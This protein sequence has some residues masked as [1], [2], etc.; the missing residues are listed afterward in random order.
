M[1]FRSPNDV[2]ASRN[3]MT[4]DLIILF[5]TIRIMLQLPTLHNYWLQLNFNWFR[6]RWLT[7]QWKKRLTGLHAQTWL[8]IH[9]QAMMHFTADSNVHVIKRIDGG[10]D[11]FAAEKST[12]DQRQL[13]SITESIF[14]NQSL[15]HSLLFVRNTFATNFPQ[16]SS[17]NTFIQKH[18]A[19]RPTKINELKMPT[20]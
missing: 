17:N 20:N 6:I 15:V 1:R 13:F 12:F 5:N 18:T 4:C 16:T 9:T 11:Q 7:F 19:K 2:N 14:I 10:A 8:I 3:S